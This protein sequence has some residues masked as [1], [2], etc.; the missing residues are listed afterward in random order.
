MRLARS[1]RTPVTSWAS[2]RIQPGRRLDQP[3]DKAGQSGFAASALADEAEHLAGRDLEGDVVHRPQDAPPR[4]RPRQAEAPSPM[5]A[6]RSPQ[7]IRLGQPLHRKLAPSARDASGGMSVGRRRRPRRAE[8]AAS[9]PAAGLLIARDRIQSSA[10]RRTALPKRRSAERRRSPREA[11]SGRESGRRSGRD[12]GSAAL[13]RAAGGKPGDLLCRDG[14]RHP[15]PRPWPR[16]PR[17]CPA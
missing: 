3:Q 8:E 13:A 14:R 5:C 12:A 6:M 17:P 9:L 15:G 16:V 7:D 2:K 10:V 1:S 11:A 4:P